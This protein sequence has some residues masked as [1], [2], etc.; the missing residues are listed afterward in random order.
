MGIQP[1]ATQDIGRVTATEPALVTTFL[2]LCC[3]TLGLAKVNFVF[4]KQPYGHITHIRYS[5]PS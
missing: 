4:K 1:Q 3:E 5:P 2:R